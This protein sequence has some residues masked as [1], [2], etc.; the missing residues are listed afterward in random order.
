MQTSNYECLDCKNIWEYRK[1]SIKE[2]FPEKPECP[3]CKS[4]NTRRDFASSYPNTYVNEG[5]LGNARTGYQTNPVAFESGY[6]K[7]SNSDSS[8]E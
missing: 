8:W 5:K 3:K 7:K 1:E 4:S 6:T 2:N